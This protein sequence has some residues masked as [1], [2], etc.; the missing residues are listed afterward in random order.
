MSVSELMVTASQRH[1]IP[2][3]G[4]PYEE[5]KVPEYTSLSFAPHKTAHKVTGLLTIEFLAKDT[6]MMMEDKDLMPGVHR[7]N[8]LSEA[9]FL[10]LSLGLLRQNKVNT[11]MEQKYLRRKLFIRCKSLKFQ[12]WLKVFLLLSDLNLYLNFVCF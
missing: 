8:K 5:D 3:Q 9:K 6:G 2:L 7:Y 12:V 11:L 4:R 10:T 1:V